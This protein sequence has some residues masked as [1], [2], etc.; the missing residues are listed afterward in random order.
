MPNAKRMTKSQL[1][2]EIAEKTEL[3][4]KQ[5]SAVFEAL[6]E[7]AKVQLGKRGPGEFVVPDMVK[8]KVRVRKAEKGKKFRNPATGEIIVKDVPASRRLVARPVKKLKDL[9]A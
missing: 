4:R 1:V 5:V 8:L 7:V 2:T 3:T 9:V 6:R